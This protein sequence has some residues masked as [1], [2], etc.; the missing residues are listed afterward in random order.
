MKTLLRHLAYNWQKK[1]LIA[2]A[3]ITLTVAAQAQDGYVSARSFAESQGIVY[4]WFPIQKMLLMRKGTKS[5]KLRPNDVVAV[6]DNTEVQLPAPPKIQDGQIMIPAA[7]INSFFQETTNAVPAI[8]PPPPQM[9]PIAETPAP[10]KPAPA[11]FIEDSSEAVLL[12]LRH[13]VREDHTRVVLEFSAPVT[14]RGEFKGN[15]YRLIISGCRNLIPTKRTNP[16][17]R[18]IAKLDINSGSDR[19]GLVLSFNL[20]QKE[21][22]PTVETLV[23]PFRMI[24]SLPSGTP[25][26]VA[27]ATQLIA[28]APA[29][30]T[31]AK[32][33]SVTEKPQETVAEPAPEINIEVPASAQL[34][35]AFSGRTVVIDPG[36]GGRDKG[37]IFSGRPEENQI[38]LSIAQHLKAKLEETGLKAVIT[39]TD[40]TDMSQSQRIAF[41][42]RQG[43]DIY[44]SIHT[45]GSTD[46]SKAGIACYYY[47]KD[48]TNIKEAEQGISTDA[49]FNEWFKNTRFDLAL[50][51]AKKVNETMIQQLKV[52]SRGIHSMPLLPLKF[53]KNPAI[54]IETGMLSEKTEGKNLISDK[55]RKALAQSISNAVVEFF[56]GIVIKP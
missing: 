6:V 26:P 21:K 28:S 44:I 19:K 12:A 11:A 5:V 17:G 16:S 22:E 7:V 45:G 10:P 41:A 18:D 51:L 38:N 24:I 13:S 46:Q 55:Y 35:P 30:L 23:E 9:I 27:T 29:Q 52:E 25:T 34:N 8:M 4:Q 54:L 43:G 37:F 42:N 15:S 32:E 31:P 49:V 36:H 47:G 39:R 40:D 56:N 14:Y 20:N 1:A 50:F 48:G 2:M 53:I 33:T 3:F